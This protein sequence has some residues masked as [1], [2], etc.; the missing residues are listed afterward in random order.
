MESAVRFVDSHHVILSKGKGLYEDD[1][2]GD[3]EDDDFDSDEEFCDDNDAEEASVYVYYSHKN[4]RS[5]HMLGT[6]KTKV[7]SFI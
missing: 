3:V 1:K 2:L 7:S 4:E 5:S 6:A